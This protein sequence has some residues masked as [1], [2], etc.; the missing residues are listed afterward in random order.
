MDRKERVRACY[1]HACLLYVSN[2]KMTNQSLR[3]RFKLP[4]S[5]ADA[6]SR[7]IADAVNDG[8]IKADDPESRSRRYAKYIPYWA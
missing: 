1:Q 8:V 3:N 6:A 5:K 2:K 4:E 7:I